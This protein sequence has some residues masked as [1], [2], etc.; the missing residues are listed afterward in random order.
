MYHYL[1]YLGWSHF[2]CPAAEV[3]KMKQE[4]SPLL[5]RGLDMDTRP[6]QVTAR[7]S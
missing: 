5:H 6:H 7:F 1:N 2:T 4:Q 3:L